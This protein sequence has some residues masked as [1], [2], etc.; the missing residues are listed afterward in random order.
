[1]QNLITQ[2]IK[3]NNVKLQN[4]INRSDK[5]LKLINNIKNL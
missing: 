4:V 5:D 2:K 3:K 1:M